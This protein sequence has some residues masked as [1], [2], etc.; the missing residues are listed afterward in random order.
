MINIRYPP[1]LQVQS[2]HESGHWRYSTQCGRYG[3]YV[4]QPSLK[5][6]NMK[7]V[8]STFDKRTFKEQMFLNEDFFFKP[9]W[10]CSRE[11]L[12]HS[13]SVPGSSPSTGYYPSGVSHIHL[14]SVRVSSGFSFH[15]PKHA[16]MC[17][18]GALCWTS[19]PI[20]PDSHP[21]FSRWVLDPLQ[22][23]L[24][25][26]LSMNEWWIFP[27][28]IYNLHIYIQQHTAWFNNSLGGKWFFRLINASSVV[29]ILHVTFLYKGNLILSGS[30]QD[31]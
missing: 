30:W 24:M 6:L 4:T 9:A 31:L 27:E 13:S 8:I 16:G 18:Y 29:N 20:H 5:G 3:S 14:A 19:Y 2:K 28:I 23:W 1:L 7:L 17:V 12:P 25:Q 10:W 21:M 26:W 11:L 15:L 22:P